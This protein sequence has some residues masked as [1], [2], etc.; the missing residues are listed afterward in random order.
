MRHESTNSASVKGLGMPC[1]RSCLNSLHRQVVLHGEILT[2]VERALLHCEL[3]AGQ[4]RA[5]CEKL[6]DRELNEVRVLIRKPGFQ[7]DEI[8]SRAAR[9]LDRI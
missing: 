9:A 1:G 5:V 2:E 3:D 8:G 4:A 6:T 7:L